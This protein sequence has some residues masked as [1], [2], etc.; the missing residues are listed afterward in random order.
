MRPVCQQGGTHV[1]ILIH[2]YQAYSNDMEKIGNYL[3]L[4]NPGLLVYCSSSN[5]GN[6]KDK[7]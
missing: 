6:S 2:G 5:E 4:L 1:V 7:I 3:K